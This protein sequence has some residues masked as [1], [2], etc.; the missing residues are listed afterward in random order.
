M[1]GRRMGHAH[2]RPARRMR[3]IAAPLR[4]DARGALAAVT[5]GG[6]FGKWHEMTSMWLRFGV[7]YPP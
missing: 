2:S 5:S 1:E 4:H 6:Y 7:D 3:R